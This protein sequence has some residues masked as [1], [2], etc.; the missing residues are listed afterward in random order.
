M[1]R[2]F[3]AM[4]VHFEDLAIDRIEKIVAPLGRIRATRMFEGHGIYAGLDLVMIVVGERVY[5]KTDRERAETL[6][7]MGGQKFEWTRPETGDT[8]AM[9]YVSLPES[10]VTDGDALLAA[11]Q[12][13]LDISADQRRKKIKSPRRFALS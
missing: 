12:I 8:I 11:A 3:M 5:V 4:T 6:L 10:S 7:A 9:S 1:Q 2:D 13:S